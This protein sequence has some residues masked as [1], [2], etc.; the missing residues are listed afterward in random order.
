MSARQPRDQIRRA[1][2]LLT[3]PPRPQLDEL[4]RRSL[5]GRLA[6][7]R[8]RALPP[9]PPLAVVAAVVVVAL[10]AGSVLVGPALV[11]SA[12]RGLAGL[13]T[14]P[15]TAA[16]PSSQARPSSAQPSPIAA[17]PTAAP[18]PTATPT[19]APPPTPVAP[20]G[21]SCAAQSGGAGQSTMTT[22][23]V[24]AQSGYDRFVIQFSGGVPQYDVEL[25]DSA[26]FPPG[27]GGVTLQ[28]AAGLSV[29]LHG[30]SGSGFTGP[31]DAQPGYQLIREAKLLSDSGGTVE[32]GIGISRAAC[33]HAWVLSDPSRLVVDIAQ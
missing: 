31:T 5:F 3:R 18:T 29:V 21:Y 25:Q 16:S 33:F 32:W 1:F 11:G 27:G 4:I 19:P 28:G 9:V 7:S 15:R 23:R 14:A 26:S 17:T 2:A 13:L 10:V 12:R 24:G 30:A 8:A 20:P 6:P 22:A